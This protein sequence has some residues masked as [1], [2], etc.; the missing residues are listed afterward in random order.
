MKKIT[1]GT[2]QMFRQ[3]V[4][5]PMMLS[6]CFAPFLMGALIKWGIPFI[7]QI[8]GYSLVPYYP[9]FD[10]L[11]SIMA[12]VLLCFAF[13]M[14]TLEEVDDNISRYFSVSPLGKSGYLFTRIGVPAI[15]SCILALIVLNFFSL[16]QLSFG[17]MAGLTVLGAVQAVIVSLM[18]VTLSS[19]KLEGMAVT[20]LSA[21]TILG[22]PVPFFVPSTVQYTVGFLPSFWVG[23]AMQSLSC[24]YF[25]ISFAVASVWFFILAGKLTKKL[26]G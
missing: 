6:A 4:H 1:A 25:V 12:P 14:I 26:A 22:I 7:E 2:A 8:S 5:D 18:I 24:P 10:T 23:K 16:E 11:L 15:L 19:N 13:A 3:I 17:M 9:I 21:L 20:K